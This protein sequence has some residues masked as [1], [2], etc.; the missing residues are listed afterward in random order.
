MPADRAPAA[1]TAPD[2][3]AVEDGR[4]SGRIA[5]ILLAAGESSRMG[6]DKMMAEI[7][8]TTLLRRAAERA[9]EAGLD[10]L[11][12]VLGVD[13]GAH[14]SELEG[15]DAAVVEN[16]AP[17][18]GKSRSVR[19]GLGRVPEDAAAAVVMLADMPL[20]TAGMLAG[21]AERYRAGEGPI[22]ASRYG[23]VTAP[24]ILYDRSMFDALAAMTGEGCGKAVVKAHPDLVVRIDW[25]EAA[26]T[27]VDRPE[28][29]ERVR[30]ALAG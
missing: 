9:R 3:D 27:D 17:E 20:V 28:D 10:P 8:G 26:L 13:R 12:V 29:L 5:A 18:A 6:R 24:P 11:V 25:P 2:P 23:D 14:R 7:G 19:L 16:D 22:V 1:G 4:A 30:A 21:L 15:L